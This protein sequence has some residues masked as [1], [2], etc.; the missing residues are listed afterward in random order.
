MEIS[1]NGSAFLKAD[2]VLYAAIEKYWKAKNSEDNFWHFIHK[3]KD[4]RA[5]TGNSKVLKKCFGAA[6]KLPFMDK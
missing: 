1:E 3:T 2:A 6:S 5:H 4:I